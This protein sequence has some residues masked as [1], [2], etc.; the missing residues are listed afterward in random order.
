MRYSLSRSQGLSALRS[1]EGLKASRTGQAGVGRCLPAEWG[2]GGKAFVLDGAWS[3]AAG[4]ASALTLPSLGSQNTSPSP[5]RV[6]V[7]R[8]KRRVSAV[9]QKGPPGVEI[10]ANS[11][12]P[13]STPGYRQP[14]QVA[15]PRPFTSASERGN[16]RVNAA[17]GAESSEAKLPFVIRGLREHGGLAGSRVAADLCR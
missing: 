3:D 15:E 4:P 5:S 16:P 17:Q 13:I 10:G 7:L 14:I 9:T 2:K 12:S 8:K 11:K 6:G 1:A